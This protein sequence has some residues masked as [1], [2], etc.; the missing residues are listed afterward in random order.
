[1]AMGPIV[2]FQCEALP[3]PDLAPGQ[4]ANRDQRIAAVV[5][6]D[7]PARLLIFPR[8]RK[9]LVRMDWATPEWRT[10][11]AR[12]L[13]NLSAVGDC[14]A[15][16]H[17]AGMTQPEAVQWAKALDKLLAQGHFPTDTERPSAT[18]LACADAALN[19]VERHLQLPDE[20]DPAYF[21]TV[22]PTPP[23]ASSSNRF[24]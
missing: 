5:R 18:E 10:S 8:A 4:P 24:S 9:L 11:R 13:L 7:H 15:C 3:A 12:S 21:Q 14:E 22:T 17:K 20:R 2:M 16:M 23:R 1:M 6:P 19:W